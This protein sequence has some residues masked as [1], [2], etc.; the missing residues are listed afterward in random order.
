MSNSFPELSF[1]IVDLILSMDVM[2]EYESQ[3][4]EASF[5]AMNNQKEVEE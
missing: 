2:P 3:L 4:R 5:K 1:F